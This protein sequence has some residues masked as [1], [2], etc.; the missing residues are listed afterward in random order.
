MRSVRRSV[1]AVAACGMVVCGL[2]F[3]AAPA[4]AGE[5]W[6]VG[7]TF[8][9]APA[10]P[11]PLSDPTWVAVNESTGDVYVVDRGNSRV[12]YFSSTG[13]YLG[14]FN[15]SSTP[16]ES[17]SSPGQIA[18]DN[19]C[20][21]GGLSEPECKESDP[22][23]DDVY[24]IDRDHNV[25]DKF[26]ASGV[27]LGQIAAGAK[28]VAFKNGELLGIAVDTGGELWADQAVEFNGQ[29]GAGPIEFDEFSNAVANV[30]GTFREGRVY[31]QAP[32]LALDAGGNFYI[33][34]SGYY[35]V[36]EFNPEGENI[37]QG[38]GGG[39]GIAGL[40]VE[41]RSNDLYI[42]TGVYESDIGTSIRVASP[43][44][45]PIESF[46][47]GQL[48]DG[49]GLAVDPAS[50]DVYVAEAA[51]NSVVF[52]EHSATPQNPPLVPSTKPATEVTGFRRS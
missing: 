17:F 52:F 28:G 13:S 33:G 32:G 47:A 34:S 21:Q 15:G 43:L 22:S 1:A 3:G 14:Q 39:V 29:V 46:G 12:E 40:T 25:I 44:T 10:D 41:P 36:Q 37:A 2:V 8:G 7:G 9:S 49:G 31:Y 18:I 35:G 6:G 50:G 51:S 42:D 24:V 23:A 5:V 19:S 27:Y 4:L 45:G 20:Y 11:Q 16:A 30:M 48:S 38:I 26:T